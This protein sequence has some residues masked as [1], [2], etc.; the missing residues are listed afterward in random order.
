M[1]DETKAWMDKFWESKHDVQVRTI[2]DE[3]IKL[4]EAAILMAGFRY[5]GERLGIWQMDVA[6]WVL[7]IVVFGY[8]GN[9][10][11][12]AASGIM[13]G[14]SIPKRWHDWRIY[15][16]GI[17]CG[18]ILAT[19]M[20]LLVDA[21]VLSTA[22]QGSATPHAP[23]LPACPA[24]AGIP[25][26]ANSGTAELKSAGLRSSPSANLQSPNVLPSADQSRSSKPEEPKP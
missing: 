3:T 19:G 18:L 22:L 11:S 24:P 25:S 4:S 9:R 5:A 14:R 21:V 6:Y 8:V 13:R 17:G 15:A 2:F 26:R 1:Y 10:A 7:L 12:L 20:R 23:S 16:V